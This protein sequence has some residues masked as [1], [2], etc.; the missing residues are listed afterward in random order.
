MS[1]SDA[2]REGRA[3]FEKKFNARPTDPTLRLM[4]CA[5]WEANESMQDYTGTEHLLVAACFIPESKELLASL[6]V[7][8]ERV[9]TGLI[10]GRPNRATRI[11]NRGF[12]P[13]A[14]A[15]ISSAVAEAQ[16]LS[17]Q[18]IQPTHIVLGILQHGEGVAAGVLGSM[19]VSLPKSRDKVLERRRAGLVAEESTDPDPFIGLASVRRLLMNPDVSPGSKKTVGSVLRELSQIYEPKPRF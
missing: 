4:D 9:R 14:D 10:I 8:E 15:V 18:E 2:F 5:I 19:G 7:S 1:E 11:K 6:G 17:D 16:R 13:E 12:T 3:R